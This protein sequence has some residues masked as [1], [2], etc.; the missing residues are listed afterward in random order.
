MFGEKNRKDE[1]ILAPSIF[2]SKSP[3]EMNLLFKDVFPSKSI[4]RSMT[5]FTVESR[6]DQLTAL[7]ELYSQLS[8]NNWGFMSLLINFENQL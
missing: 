7:L 6:T 5:G 1:M 8:S 4:L 3:G 2:Q